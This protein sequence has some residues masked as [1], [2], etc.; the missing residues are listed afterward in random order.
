M[1]VHIMKKIIKT[2]TQARFEREIK[3]LQN[4]LGDHMI[5]INGGAIFCYLK[6]MTSELPDLN[7][8]TSLKIFNHGHIQNLIF[9]IGT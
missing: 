8:L 6:N 7:I 2:Y 3:T 9:L 4:A 5:L 1:V